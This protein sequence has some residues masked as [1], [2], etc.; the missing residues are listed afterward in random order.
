M[1]QYILE[2]PNAEETVSS[3]VAYSVVTRVLQ[4]LK[5]FGENLN[6]VFLNNSPQMTIKGSDLDTALKDRSQN[7]LPTDAQIKIEVD[8]RY[9]ENMSRSTA[10]REKTEYNIFNCERTKTNMHPG[11]QQMISTVNISFRFNNRHAAE[12]FRRKMRL[13]ATKSV[14]G[15][16]LKVKYSYIIPYAFLG[17]LEHIYT[18]MEN[19]HGY[20]I[21]LNQWLQESFCKNITTLANQSGGKSVLA[22]SEINT[23]VLVLL[24]N[25]DEPERKE[26]ENDEDAWT[27]NLQFDAYYDRPDVMRISFQHLINNQ[28][29]DM[30]YINQNRINT[31][32][33]EGSRTHI[34]L[35]NAKVSP[36]LIAKGRNAIAAATSPEFDD[37]LPQRATKDYPDILRVMIAVDTDQPTFVLDLNDISDWQLSPAVLNYLKTKRESISNLYHN[38]FYIRLWEWD[39]MVADTE[40]FLDEN[41][42]LHFKGGLDPRKNYHVTIGMCYDPSKLFSDAWVD[43]PDFIKEYIDS[44]RPEWLDT[45][46]HIVN[47]HKDNFPDTSEKPWLEIED[48]PWTVDKDWSVVTPPI[49]DDLIGKMKDP[50]Y[51]NVP[52]SMLTGNRAYRMNTVMIY[53]I[54]F[55]REKD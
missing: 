1:P 20:G 26:K 14:D 12:S 5:F 28:L 10:I 33:I 16:N 50:T 3:P 22:I 34:A 15:M 25:P 43:E 2:I 4:T 24:A 48:D 42:M 37:W 9:N 54:I 45:L 38:F 19:Q 13:A 55:K 17:L 35:Q 30:K 53:G 18:L 39:S 41:L 11:Y 29:V 31:P 8:E 6:I 46:E 47:E 40:V 49:I 23:N 36:G 52:K 27:V 7:R 21:S 32:N 51:T 44:T